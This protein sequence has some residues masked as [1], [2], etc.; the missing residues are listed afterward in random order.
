MR[1]IDVYFKLGNPKMGLESAIAGLIAG[2]TSTSIPNCGLVLLVTIFID[3]PG[4]CFRASLWDADGDS[5]AASN[6]SRMLIS[7][8]GHSQSLSLLAAKALPIQSWFL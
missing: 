2:T 1:S 8:I 7:F 3:S 5:S 6:D 4:A